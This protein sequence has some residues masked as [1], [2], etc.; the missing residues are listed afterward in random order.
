MRFWCGT[1]A[2]RVVSGC[3]RVAGFSARNP[4]IR[5]VIRSKSTASSLVSTVL[6]FVDTH[7]QHQNIRIHLSGIPMAQNKSS[8]STS[9]RFEF[10]AHH[11]ANATSRDKEAHPGDDCKK[12]DPTILSTVTYTEPTSLSLPSHAAGRKNGPSPTIR[13][14]TS[15]SAARIQT[16]IDLRL[17]TLER[18]FGSFSPSMRQSRP[19]IAV[20]GP[21]SRLAKAELV[22]NNGLSL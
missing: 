20:V 21:S 3:A 8:Q 1:R 15:K 22:C 9:T 17:R 5:S 14:N 2:V 16:M 13:A 6:A 10:L 19:R 7:S 12:H 18:H 4:H 11:R